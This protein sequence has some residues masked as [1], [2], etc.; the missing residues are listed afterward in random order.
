MPSE[1]IKTYS[2]QVLLREDYDGDL[3]AKELQELNL[4]GIIERV[5]N[6]WYFRKKGASTWIKIGESSNKAD[7]FSVRWDLQG[8]ANGKYEVL[9]LMH[10]SVRK[11]DSKYTIARQNVV[12]VV[13][14]N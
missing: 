5:D 4:S 9:G 8:L 3:L 1:V 13:V 14:R 10:V 6:P 12:E 11:G 7:N 2:G